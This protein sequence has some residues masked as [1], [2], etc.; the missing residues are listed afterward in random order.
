VLTGARGFIR[1]ELGRRIRAK[2]IP[3]LEF[4]ADHG[5][6]Y[7]LKIQEVLRDL[8]L[9]REETRE[10]GADAEGQADADGRVE[11]ESRVEPEGG[12]EPTGRAE[13]ESRADTENRPSA[14][15]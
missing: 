7:S 11:P 13:P 12:A 4:R 15:E 5:S 14:E 10:T 1:T 9:S 6:E 2:R 8:G 3:E